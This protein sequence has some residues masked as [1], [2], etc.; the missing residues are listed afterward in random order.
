MRKFYAS[1]DLTA[2]ARIPAYAT[3]S[4][5]NVYRHGQ[6]VEL[7]DKGDESGDAK[8]HNYGDNKFYI[9]PKGCY[10]KASK[11]DYPEYFLWH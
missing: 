2:R 8:W 6:I 1:I 10:K 5:T 9:I 11:K 4:I 3:S 7:V